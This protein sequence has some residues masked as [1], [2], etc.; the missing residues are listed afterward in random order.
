LEN[1]NI[2]LNQTKSTAGVLNSLSFA[3][4][5]Q[6]SNPELP[7]NLGENQPALFAILTAVSY[8]NILKSLTL[9][10]LP[11]KLSTQQV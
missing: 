2:D 6:P 11:F 8:F 9:N 3:K 1:L 7:R 10:L 5:G 4:S